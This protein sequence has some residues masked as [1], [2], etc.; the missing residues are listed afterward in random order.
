[1]KSKLMNLKLK[2]KWKTFEWIESDR[3]GEKES[4]KEYKTKNS[5]QNASNK[6]QYK[7]SEREGI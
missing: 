3:W 7:Y 2:Q 6:K 5:L 1:M 4:K